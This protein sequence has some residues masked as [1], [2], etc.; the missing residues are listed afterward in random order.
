MYL[1]SG[2]VLGEV[3]GGNTLMIEQK[4]HGTDSFLKKMEFLC[5]SDSIFVQSRGVCF[6]HSKFRD[7]SS[8]VKLFRRSTGPRFGKL[9][10]FHIAMET[11]ET[12]ELFHG[13]LRGGMPTPSKK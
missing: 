3:S 9:T 2:V 4:G 5:L 6:E 13:N 10:T 1:N 7:V 8:P 12:R 11:M